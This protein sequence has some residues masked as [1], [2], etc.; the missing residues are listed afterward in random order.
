MIYEFSVTTDSTIVIKE[1]SDLQ[2]YGEM[3]I[4]HAA[5]VSKSMIL[6]SPMG[7]AKVHISESF[8]P[9]YGELSVT[10]AQENKDDSVTFA[11]RFKVTERL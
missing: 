2:R 6:P 1:L 5:I 7:L 9:A 10:S 3:A 11:C 8:Y 4:I